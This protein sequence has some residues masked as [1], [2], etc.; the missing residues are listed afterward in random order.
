VTYAK[1][2]FDLQLEFA[3]RVSALSGLPLARTVLEYTNFFIRFGLGRGFDPAHPIWQ[4]YLAGLPEAG[5][6]DE[7]TYR[8]YL[9]RSQGTGAPPV[10]ATFGCFSY[11]LSSG[12][13]VRL[14]FENAEPDGSSPLGRDRVSWRLAELASLFDHVKQTQGHA[15]QVLGASWLYNL[16]AYRRLFPKS[17]LASAHAIH[18]RFQHMPLWGQFVDRHGEIKERLTRPFLERIER[19]SRLDRL[20]QCFPFQVLSVRAP[21]AEFYDFYGLTDDGPGRERN[22]A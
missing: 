16:E 20:E 7:W 12:D 9:T 8:F 2:F 3:L 21:V 5:D 13:A 6:A 15:R 10:V 14:H 17:Y 18:G 4:E 22:R 19:E 1:A 11:A